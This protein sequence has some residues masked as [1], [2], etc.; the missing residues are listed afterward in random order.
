MGGD[1]NRM[2][3]TKLTTIVGK[4]LILRPITLDDTDLI[5]KWRN[6]PSVVQNFIFR[7][8][9]TRQMHE[10]WMHNKVETGQVIQYIVEEKK[11]NRPIGSVYF[12]DVNENYN[13]AEFG[14]FI[15]EDD[16]RGKG[17]GKEITSL[18]V[19]FGIESLGL[20]RIQLRLVKGNA[21]AARTY[22]SVG[23]HKEGEF[24][25]MV[26]LSDEY[27]TVIFMSILD[28]DIKG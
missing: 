21:A 10:N 2:N 13:S 16:A 11:N 9:F 7:E 27:R 14:I 22:T 26:K 5:V 3:K 25:D 4:N 20:H 12:R 1:F 6:N 17:Y 19:R 28:T 24:R 8:K 23:F 18:F 15:G